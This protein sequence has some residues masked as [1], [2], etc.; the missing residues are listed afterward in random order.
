MFKKTYKGLDVSDNLF[1]MHKCNNAILYKREF[2]INKKM[3]QFVKDVNSLKYIAIPDNYDKI[4][5]EKHELRE[6]MLL[7]TMYS[8]KMNDKR[9]HVYEQQLSNFKKVYAYWKVLTR[10]VFLTYVMKV[11][12]Y[13]V[14]N[15]YGD[16]ATC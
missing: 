7:Q 3:K 9:Y 13:L 5:R 12:Q 1:D 14:N 8:Y 15:F 2:I 4:A 16:C 10:D 11:P 6:L